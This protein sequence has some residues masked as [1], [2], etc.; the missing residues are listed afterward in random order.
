[1]LPRKADNNARYGASQLPFFLKKNAAILLQFDC[2]SEVFPVIFLRASN[3]SKTPGRIRRIFRSPSGSF[4][5]NCQVC[6]P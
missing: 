4:V 1:M 6:I 2:F 5:R 3:S